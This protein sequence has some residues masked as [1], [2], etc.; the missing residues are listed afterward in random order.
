MPQIS[1]IL[2]VYNGIKYLEESITSVLQQD[3]NNFEFLIVD[4]CSTDSSWEY[5][6]SLKDERI[7]LFK[8]K[9]LGLLTLSAPKLKMFVYN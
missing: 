2:P 3:Y 5:L 7:K 8:N 4:D 9:L 1:I 6:L